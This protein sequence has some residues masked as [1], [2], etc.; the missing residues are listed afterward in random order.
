MIT[1]VGGEN[2]D[3]LSER[4]L[5]WP[6]R[7]ILILSDIHL[8]KAESLQREGIAMPADSGETDLERMAQLITRLM[9]RQVWVLG[10]FIHH[11]HSWTEALYRRLAEFF[12]SFAHIQWNLVLGN[13]ER[14]SM[15]SLRKLPFVL[16]EGEISLGPFYL[17]HGHS[18]QK[19]GADDRL[20]IEG[21]VHPVINLRS[22]PLRL[23]L[24][25]FVLQKNRF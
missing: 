5:H 21:H 9:P 13:H 3:L 11:R 18:G 15:E 12:H 20:S 25:C 23:R 4:A 1:D 14:G 19:G 2:L 16:H 6:S 7:E 22:G 24:P 10:D 17:A 8:G